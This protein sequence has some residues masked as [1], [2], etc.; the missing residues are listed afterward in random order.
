MTS[1]VFILGGYQTDFARCASR[2]GK[3]YSDLI[4]EAVYG[5]VADAQVDLSQI[6]TVH[7]GNAM[8]ELY[9]GQA[10][11]GPIVAQVVPKLRGLPTMR[12]EGACA[13]SSLAILAAAAEIEAGRYDCALIVGVEEERRLPGSEAGRVQNSAGWLE[14]EDIDCNLMWAAVF[15]RIAHEYDERFGIDRR[16]LSRIAEINYAN[17]KANPLAQT[18]TWSFKEGAFSEDD[19]T[20]PVVEPGTRRIDCTHITDGAATLVLASGLFLEEHLRRTG[21]KPHEIARI[22]GW[23]HRGAG[24]R[25]LDKLEASRGQPFVMP[26]LREAIKDAWRRAGIGGT[27]QLDG[28]ETHDCFTTNE[29]LAIDHFGITAPGES[30]KAIEDGRIERTGVIP[31]NASGGLI[32]IG[33]PIGATGARM[34]LDAARQVTRKAGD[35]QIEGAKTYQTLN[36]GGSCATVVSLVLQQHE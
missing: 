11:M 1:P 35:Y 31:V 5:A 15:G 6:E 25:F 22:R 18:R 29:Y 14:R 24:I 36:I 32:G 19:V 21:R 8:G 26:H 9:N 13:S 20:N 3:D 17:A 10:H 23:G 4:A 33:H 7:V 28:I 2:E 30:W 12:H 27:E 34:T 16:H